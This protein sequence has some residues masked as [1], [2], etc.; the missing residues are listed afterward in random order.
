MLSPGASVPASCHIPFFQLI[1]MLSAG[2]SSSASHHV[3]CPLAPPLHLPLVCQLVVALPLLLCRRPLSF[4]QPAASASRHATASCPHLLLVAS[5]LLAGC[6]DASR[7]ATTTLHHLLSH[8]RL[9]C[10]SL[11]PY[12]HLHWLVVALHLVALPPPPVLLSTPPP[13][14]ALLPYV[15]PATPIPVCLPF[16]RTG[17]HIASCGTAASHLPACPPLHLRLLSHLVLVCPG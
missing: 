11:T 13:L 3:S 6:H 15:A 4:F 1:V 9:T 14:N 10:P 7:R 17:C 16:T 12:L 5:C 2:I 8:H